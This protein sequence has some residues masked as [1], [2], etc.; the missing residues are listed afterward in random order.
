MDA[1]CVGE[2]Q[3]VG[4]ACRAVGELQKQ[5]IATLDDGTF[6]GFTHVADGHDLLCCALGP[7]HRKYFLISQSIK[8]KETNT[9]NS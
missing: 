2:L 9:L 7:Q 3:A 8:K 5:V 6:F 1:S 4:Q